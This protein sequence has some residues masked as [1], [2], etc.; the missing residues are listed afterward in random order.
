MHK[1][2][3]QQQQLHTAGNQNELNKENK[4]LAS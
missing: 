3:W 1:Q 2:A 4:E